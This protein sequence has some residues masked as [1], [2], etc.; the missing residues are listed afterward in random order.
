MTLNNKKKWECL[1]DETSR[2]FK[3]FCIYRDMG[4][5]R[6]IGA[7]AREWSE[8]GA[9]SRLNEWSRKH[10]WV[11]RALNYDEHVDEIRRAKQ[12]QEIVEMSARHVRIARN[13]DKI[14]KRLQSIN[15][16]DLSPQD[17]ARWYDTSVKIERISLGV[18]TENIKQEQEVT[19]I[20][21]ESTIEAFKNPETRKIASK[22]I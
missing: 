7:V 21:D 22:L 3:A 17:L 1:Q 6:S 14:D 13:F 19:E 10:Q 8:S 15:P 11:E 18:P 2:Q 16:N 12:E 9:T 4:V 5:E 20:K